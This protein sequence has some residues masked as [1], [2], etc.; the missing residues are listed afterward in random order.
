MRSGI[1]GVKNSGQRV[2]SETIVKSL[3][4]CGISNALDGSEDDILYEERDVPSEN[5]RED[6]FSGS[7]DNF[8]GFYDE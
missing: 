3:K 6:D 8:L 4:K 1:S 2:K 5:N 7:D